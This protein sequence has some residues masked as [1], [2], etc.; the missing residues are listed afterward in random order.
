MLSGRLSFHQAKGEISIQGKATKGY[1]SHADFAA[2]AKRNL[3][4]TT[5]DPPLD[6]DRQRFIFVSPLVTDRVSR[7]LPA[8]ANPATKRRTLDADSNPAT[9][10]SRSNQVLPA[11]P[12]C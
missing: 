11:C 5:P 6:P 10:S 9:G 1:F 3:A 8:H 7:R 12:T 2:G 4:V